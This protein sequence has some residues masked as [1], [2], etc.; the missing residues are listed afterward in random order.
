MKKLSRKQREIEARRA[1]D[2]VAQALGR[3]DIDYSTD[4]LPT[5]PRSIVVKLIGEE[6]NLTRPVRE[7][8]VK[9][10]ATCTCVN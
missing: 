2:P 8:S 10:C 9:H 7:I 1:A 5:A 6:Q 4:E 3:D